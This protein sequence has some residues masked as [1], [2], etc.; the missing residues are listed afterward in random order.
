MSDWLI[1]SG[2]VRSFL[3]CV[4][5]VLSRAGRRVS[6]VN[7]AFFSVT[8][9]GWEKEKE[10]LASVWG[11]LIIPFAEFLPYLSSVSPLILF[12]TMISFSRP[13]PTNTVLLLDVVFNHHPFLS[14][15]SSFLHTKAHTR[16]YGLSFAHFLINPGFVL[17]LEEYLLQQ[18]LLTFLLP[19]RDLF[20]LLSSFFVFFF[21]L[22]DIFT[23]CRPCL[24][25]VAFTNLSYVSWRRVMYICLFCCYCYCVSS[26]SLPPPLPNIVRVVW[27][28]KK[29][30]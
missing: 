19:H 5:L 11:S 14:S 23:T 25:N 16:A 29:K 13:F 9:G 30:R 18:M 4:W 6:E 22:S 28:A 24:Y 8:R 12:L 15:S 10:D 21:W 1:N 2:R 26:L 20:F 7:P 27:K 17:L 3:V